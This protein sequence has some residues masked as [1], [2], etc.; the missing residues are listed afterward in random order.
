MV[1]YGLIECK[2]YKEFTK[3]KGVNMEEMREKSIECLNSQS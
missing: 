1:P 3:I 2:L